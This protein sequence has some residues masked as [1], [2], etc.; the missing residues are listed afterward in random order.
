MPTLFTAT[1]MQR[2]CFLDF[3][4]DYPRV[5]QTL[6]GGEWPCADI[7][8]RAMVLDDLM[9]DHEVP[10]HLSDLDKAI[11]KAAVE[12]SRWLEDYKGITDWGKGRVPEKLTV[13]RECA[14]LLEGIGIE[15]DFL[16][17]S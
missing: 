6:E 5:I 2:E 17:K 10:R 7:C 9:Q 16:P 12:K 1:N 14:K 13:L 8:F 4:A 15:V 3:L 11:M